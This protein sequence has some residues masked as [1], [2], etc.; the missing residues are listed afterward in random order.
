M[1]EIKQE[2]EDKLR[3]FPLLM[4]S[5]YE[6]LNDIEEYKEF[7]KSI[8]VKLLLNQLDGKYAA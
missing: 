2:R 3:G 8:S 7:S 4:K 5:D 6:S 1:S